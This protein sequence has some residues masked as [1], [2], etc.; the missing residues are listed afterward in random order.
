MARVSWPCAISCHC[1]DLTCYYLFDTRSSRLEHNIRSILARQ[2]VK[3]LCMV[4]HI[5]N[6]AVRVRVPRPVP[7]YYRVTMKALL[8]GRLGLAISFFFATASCRL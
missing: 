4:L 6:F 3:P 5:L 2:T 7:P 8:V 1:D